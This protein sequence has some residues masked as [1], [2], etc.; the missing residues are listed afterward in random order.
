MRL[1]SLEILVR[2]SEMI[3]PNYGAASGKRPIK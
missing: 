1:E 3:V 2:T